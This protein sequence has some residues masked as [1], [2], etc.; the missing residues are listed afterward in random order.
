MEP[1][2]ICALAV[3]VYGGLITLRDLVRDLGV[4]GIVV[5]RLLAGYWQRAKASVVRSGHDFLG[6]LAP[7]RQLVS[8]RYARTTAPLSY[9][10]A[11]Q[12]AAQQRIRGVR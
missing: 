3:V 5:S 2:L 1:I 7:P 6:W 11:V 4:E 12:H 8:Y 9:S 10:S